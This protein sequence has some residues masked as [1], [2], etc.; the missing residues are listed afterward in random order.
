MIFIFFF[1]YIR[2]WYLLYSDIYGLI[3]QMSDPD[4]QGCNVLIAEGVDNWK[5]VVYL[6]SVD[7]RNVMALMYLVW[8]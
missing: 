4:I 3:F 8:G 7:I 2:G 6:S 1:K 5:V